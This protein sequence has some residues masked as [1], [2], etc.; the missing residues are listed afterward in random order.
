[1]DL[2]IVE[3]EM[4]VLC[5]SCGLTELIGVTGVSVVYNSCIGLD[6]DDYDSAFGEFSLNI[7]SDEVDIWSNGRC[8]AALKPICTAL[9]SSQGHFY[10][11]KK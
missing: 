1:M 7:T 11:Y 10:L 3:V 4:Q 9:M 5:S 2:A 8:D 6:Y